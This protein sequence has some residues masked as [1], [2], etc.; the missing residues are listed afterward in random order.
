MYLFPNKTD[1]DGQFMNPLKEREK[2]GK[3]EEEEREERA[4]QDRRGK[5]REKWT[6]QQM[7][8]VLNSIHSE[9]N[10]LSD[11]RVLA[12]DTYLSLNES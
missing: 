9:I 1:A 11:H 7:K 3:R 5:K 4:R 8:H 2:E 12:F 10:L 6:Y